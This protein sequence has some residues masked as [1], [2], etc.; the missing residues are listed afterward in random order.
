MRRKVF[1]AVLL[2]ISAVAV[3]FY[4]YRSVEWKTFSYSAAAL[5][6]PLMGYAPSAQESELSDDI[7][8][9]YVDVTWRELEPEKGVYRWNAIEKANQFKKWR[10]EGKHLVLRFVL[11]YPGKKQHKDIPDWLYDELEDPGD[12]YDSSYGKG[13]SPN[14]QDKKLLNYYQKAVKALGEHWGKDSFISYIELGGVGHWGE[15]HVNLEAGIRPLPNERIREGYVTPWLT[16]FPEANLLMRRP[17]STAKKY[18]LGI[19]NDMAGDPASTQEWLDW[20]ESGGIYDQTGENSLAAMPNAWKTVPIG[21]EL[22]SSL[23]M[24]QLLISDLRQTVDLVKNSHTSFLG[25]K[26]AEEVDGNKKGYDR[27]LQHMGYRLWISSAKLQR[28]GGAA[29]LTTTW[30]NAGVAPFYKNWKVYAYVEDT[31]GTEL[32]KAELPIELPT[33][34]PGK[35]VTAVVNLSKLKPTKLAWQHYQISIGIVDPM[36][37]EDA[38]RF[39]VA[40]QENQKRLILFSTNEGSKSS[41]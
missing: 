18:G 25:P 21:G 12:W 4:R 27:L 16:A 20:I 29:K 7:S 39:A 19:Y 38:I 34:L 23:S 41:E 14:Y 40:G 10:A 1:F 37:G 9:L 8:L 6:N 5:G 33:V 35:Q 2:L 32:E 31:S 30:E 3:A 15:W 36:T 26:I 22:T 17:F 11:D 28:N 13:F 24:K